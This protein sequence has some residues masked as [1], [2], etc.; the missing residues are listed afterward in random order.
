MV[1]KFSLSFYRKKNFF[2]G[3]RRSKVSGRESFVEH[4][5]LLT[6][7]DS[8]IIAMPF[9]IISTCPYIAPR[10]PI[11]FIIELR[12]RREMKINSMLLQGRQNGFFD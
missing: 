6:Y 10:C 3:G 7:T 12:G 5:S 9:S 4:K 1:R 2:F 8:I 11:T